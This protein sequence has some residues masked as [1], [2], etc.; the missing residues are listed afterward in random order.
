MTPLL[1]G[2]DIGSYSSKGVLCTTDGQVVR[3]AVREHTIAFPRPGHAEQD[4]ERVW[5]ADFVS[6]SRELTAKLPHGHEVAAVATSAIGPCLLPVDE[7]GRPLRPGILYGIDTRASREIEELEDRYGR[8]ALI[9]L[10]GMR[11]T[12]QAIGPKISWLRRHEPLVYSNAAHFLTASSYVILRLTGR[13]VIDAHTASGFNP[14]IDMRLVA[15]D[16]RFADGIATLSQLPQIGWSDEI[17][18][19]VTAEAARETGLAIG[20]P[21]TFGA[22]DALAE[23]VSVG[24]DAPGDLMIMYG[25]TAFLILI[26][27][28][29][30]EQRDLWL[31]AGAHRGQ[32]AVAAGLATSGAITTW[33]AK[34]F[35]GD[36]PAAAA[37][38]YSALATEAGTSPPGSRGLLVLPYFAGERTPIHDPLA[39]GVIAGLTLSH[40]RGDVFRSILEGTAF[41]I[42]H[43]LEAMRQ[44]GAEITRV[45]A[46]GGGATNALW[47]SIVS[48][49][50]GIT[51]AIP[52]QTI[53]AAYG[54]AYLAGLAVGL[55]DRGSSWARTERHISPDPQHSE[56]YGRAYSLYRDLYEHSNG[57]MHKLA[58][59]ALD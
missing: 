8:D 35:A 42:A 43:N 18:G 9:E 24:V 3:T 13:Y 2:I 37:G 12:S 31:T 4:A 30:Y 39:R 53:G 1:L 28:A 56:L 16:D 52:A 58:A 25:S 51:Q 36:L 40:T 6:I 34:E 27:P 15:W 44:T 33:F 50:T 32:Y 55:A 5:W 57:V 46:V 22:V 17:A 38:R 45:V 10:G 59:T 20:T 23:A 48:D 41:G 47:V 19:A 29:R 21:V 14:L 54:D 7:S 49:V 26:A 11:L